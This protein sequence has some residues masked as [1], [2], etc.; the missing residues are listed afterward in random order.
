VFLL[1]SRFE[2]LPRAVLQALA[3]GVP[4]VATAVDGTPEVVR[5]RHSGLLVPPSDPEA[6]AGRLL[7]MVSDPVLRRRCIAQGRE[8]LDRGF[9]SRRMVRDLERL[10]IDLLENG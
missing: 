3:A 10:Y 4:V 8:V 1:T 9:D 5:D 2:G 7:E 6:A